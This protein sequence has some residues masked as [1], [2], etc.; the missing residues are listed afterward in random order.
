MAT[1]IIA[2]YNP[3]HNGHRHQIGCIKKLR[4]GGILACMSG[5]IT[6]RG[7]FALLDKWQRAQA[8]VKNGINLVIE[9]PTIFACRSAQDFASGG[10][11]LL[12]SLGIVDTLAFGTEYPDIKGLQAASA[13]QPDDHHDQLQ[14][15]LKQ[16][17]SYGAA[18]SQL[19]AEN[20]GLPNEMLTEPNTILAIE[21]LRALK[22]TD[23][24]APLPLL[25]TGAGHNDTA[26]SGQYASGT[27]IRRMAL[28]GNFRE[29]MPVVPGATLAEIEN[30]AMFP[31]TKKQ[32]PLIIWKLLSMDMD[33][34]GAIYGVNEGMEYRLKEAACSPACAASCKALLQELATR[35]Y[36]A[37]RIQR[38]LM[39]LL[40]ENT[41]D[42]TAEMTSPLYIRVLAFDDIGRSMLKAIRQKAQLPLIIKTTDYLGRRDIQH[43]D[44]LS[45]L[46]KMLYMDIAAANLR[47]LCLAP[48]PSNPLGEQP[49]KLQ[50]DLTTSPIYVKS[51]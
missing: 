18:V 46:Q 29:L 37:T 25:R 30:T 16:G 47:E 35:R 20:T 21:Y 15:K 40:L 44:R 5:S 17:L 33:S 32:L 48:L 26:S 34:I 7:E 6:Q 23:G 31:S 14:A 13:F 41:K 50:S 43:P 10:V 3:F 11:R 49:L 28:Q 4:D 24:I 51:L 45:P 38:I 1:G 36:P 9:L 12:A 27:A 42:T 22:K 2:E 19:I 8:A 39:H